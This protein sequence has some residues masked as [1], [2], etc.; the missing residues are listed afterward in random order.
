MQA[1]LH[2]K[3]LIAVAVGLGLGL[4]GMTLYGLLG[5]PF[6]FVLPLIGFLFLFAL[7][8]LDKFAL[9]IGAS[10]P[11]SV[12]VNDIAGGLGMSFPTE[13]IIIILFGLLIFYFIKHFSVPLHFIKH[14]LVLL[15]IGYVLWL[16]ISSVFSQHPMVSLKF[17]LARTWYIVVFF[18]GGLWFFSKYRNIRFFLIWQ[19]V[20][21]L[22]VCLFTIYMHNEFR[23]ERGASYGISWPF[24]PD[25]GMYAACIAFA[26]PIL[27]LFIFKPQRFSIGRIG[28]AACIVALIIILFAIVTSYTRAAWLS[29]IA[30]LGVYWLLYLRI[31]FKYIMAVLVLV[32]STVIINQDK[33]LYSLEA[34]KQGSSDELEGHVKSVSNIT[35]D[36]SNMERVN[37]WSC[38]IRMAQDRPIT[39]FGPGTF[40]F[41][42]GAFQKTNELTIISTFF[43]DV[44]DAHSEYFSALAETG[45]I[46]LALWA[47]IFI[48]SMAL[49]FNVYRRTQSFAIKSNVLVAL[50]ALTTYYVHGFLNNYT[51]YDKVAV[52]L[53]CFLAIL[54]SLDIRTKKDLNKN[55]QLD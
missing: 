51:Q 41:E 1:S 24:F 4:I 36:P 6:F 48:Y 47:S 30:A 34:N 15:V 14:P 10:A 40:V 35:T 13:P 12:N 26:V 19:V 23:F 38:A 54:I 42:Y 17:S 44:G 16:F 29:L 28:N 5:F 8:R 55:S 39:G 46:G 32:V 7:L 45:Y 52:P 9:I 3:G 37:R 27:C 43:G 25:H 50:L 20:F 49:A 53:W 31:K 33:I 11:L 21:T 2:H 22:L 18:F